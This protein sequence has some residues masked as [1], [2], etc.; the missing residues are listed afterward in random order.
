MTTVVAIKSADG[1]I[2]ASDSQGSNNSI[3][4]LEISK[5]FRINDSICI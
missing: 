1:I 5:I 4:D 3:K 2:L